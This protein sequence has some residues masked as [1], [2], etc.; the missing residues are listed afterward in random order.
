MDADELIEYFE[1]RCDAEAVL[2]VPDSPRQEKIAES[3]IKF[4]S[5]HYS[6]ETL[7]KT[8]DLYCKTAPKPV[9]VY[10]FAVSI[11]VFREKVLKEQALV[12]DFNKT[13]EAT[14]RRME[15]A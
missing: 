6:I 5:K 7:K 13:L 4:H 1:E 2:F 8:I 11:N 12:D 10:E 3:L 9:T 14:K 15:G